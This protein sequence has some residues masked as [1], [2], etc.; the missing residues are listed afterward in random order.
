[1]KAN[2]LRIN[3]LVFER[4]FPSNELRILKIIFGL[5][6]D[7]PSHFEPIQLTNELLF[8]SGFVKKNS[9]WLVKGNFA[10]NISFDVEWGGNWLGVRLKYVHQLQ[11]LYFAL[12]GNELTVNL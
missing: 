1:M 7:N 12:T 2:E 4:M 5:Q 9:T 3:N 8:K 10:V 11:N 6:I